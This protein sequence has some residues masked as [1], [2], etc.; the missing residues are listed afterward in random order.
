MSMQ[1][2]VRIEWDGQP[3]DIEYAMVGVDDARAPCMVFLH[4]GLGSVALWRDFPQRLCEELGLRGFVYSR[5]GY[6]GST[7]RPPELLWDPDF[8][9]RQAELVLPRVLQTAGITGTPW[10]FGHSDGASIAL[11][12]AARF[13]QSVTGVV[14]LAPHVFV[15]DLTVRNIE[16]AREAYVSGDLKPRLARY[17]ADVDSAF[18]GWNRI[19]LDARFRDWNIEADIAGA[20]CPVLVVQGLDDEYGTLEQLRKIERALPQAR[21]VE[22]ADCGHSPH[23]DQPEAVIDAVR[24]F[25][26]SLRT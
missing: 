12:H 2:S 26:E 4:E 10:L 7:P 19:W 20:Q 24:G 13:P 23:R 22:L 6:G 9:H 3:H 21:C 18:W 25:V 1:G 17:H 5:P 16:A 8:M 14:A 15:E 11:L